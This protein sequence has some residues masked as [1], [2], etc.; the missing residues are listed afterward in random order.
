VP[1]TPPPPAGPDVTATRHPTTT[2]DR[3]T[4][5]AATSTTE[6]T[7]PTGTTTGSAAIQRENKRDDPTHGE[8]PSTPAGRTSGDRRASFSE[9]RNVRPFEEV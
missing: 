2:T 3:N 9:T 8:V 1:T 7:G 4:R 6:R 5:P